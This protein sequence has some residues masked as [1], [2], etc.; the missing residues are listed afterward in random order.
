MFA[1]VNA[2]AGLPD[3]VETELVGFLLAFGLR[4]WRSVGCCG[5]RVA[6]RILGCVHTRYI[7]FLRCFGLEW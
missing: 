2:V 6:L 5:L 7:S 4:M 1:F 3:A